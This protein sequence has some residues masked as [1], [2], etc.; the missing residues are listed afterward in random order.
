MIILVSATRFQLRQPIEHALILRCQINVAVADAQCIGRRFHPIPFRA[1]FVRSAGCSRERPQPAALNSAAVQGAVYRP[2]TC[3]L[4]RRRHRL[5]D[6]SQPIERQSRLLSC[7]SC[8]V[9]TNVPS[10]IRASNAA[11]SQG[12]RGPICAC[13]ESS[14][15]SVFEVHPMVRPVV[16]LPSGCCRAFDVVSRRDVKA[17]RHEIALN[18]VRE[19]RAGGRT[20]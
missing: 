15:I 19:K 16:A 6:G 7:C 1:G 9:D 13:R 12:L 18:L 4:Q 11:S 20:A 17:A 14:R 3:Q 2:R 5:T 10:A 8:W